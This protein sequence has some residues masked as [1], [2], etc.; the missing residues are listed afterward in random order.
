MD[1]G[2][3]NPPGGQRGSHRPDHPLV[4]TK[5][6]LNPRPKGNLRSEIGHP[7]GRLPPSRKSTKRPDHRGLRLEYVT[8]SW[9]I[10]GTGVVIL[11]AVNARSVAL[12]GFALDSV[13]EDLKQ[14]EKVH[15]HSK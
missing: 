14:K 10:V 13:I 15:G 2:P 1:L 6:V 8:L 12:A 5:K 9:N 7:V 3:G 4:S 11:A